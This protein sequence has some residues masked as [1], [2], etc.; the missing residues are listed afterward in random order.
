MCSNSFLITSSYRGENKSSVW[1]LDINK[2]SLILKKELELKNP[3]NPLKDYA[4]WGIV[5]YKEGYYISH[6]HGI[7]VLDK[8]FNVVNS[9]YDREK[10][11]DCHSITIINDRIYVANTAVDTVEVFDMGLNHKKSIILKDLP[12]LNRIPTI[13]KDYKGVIS[14]CFHVNHVSVND[15]NIYFT[16]SF[17]SRKKISLSKK[18]PFL[19]FQ[20]ETTPGC[21][22]N[23]T[24]SEFFIKNIKGAHD[25]VWSNGEFVLN[26]TYNMSLDRFSKNGKHLSS[27]MCKDA[28]IYRGLLITD[29]YVIVGATKVNKSRSNAG[30]IYTE[31]CQNRHGVFE[32]ESKICVYNKNMQLIKKYSLPNISGQSPE[33]FSISQYL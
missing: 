31:M 11:R 3:I 17:I 19:F 7:T 6:A 24:K 14:D 5:T 18:I 32:K 22:Y 13:S 28:A 30:D 10:L 25:G 27:F 21:V 33:I 2:D 15:G 26:Q 12:G 8:E 23:Y 20:R 4:A 1:L 9:Y 29:E 16:L